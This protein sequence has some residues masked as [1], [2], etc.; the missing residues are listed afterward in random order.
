M[1]YAREIDILRLRTS[2]TLREQHGERVACCVPGASRRWRQVRSQRVTRP[3]AV[4]AAQDDETAAG[5]G[6][7]MVDKWKHDGERTVP[8]EQVGCELRIQRGATCIYDLLRRSP[9]STH[10]VRVP[11]RGGIV[12]RR[13]AVDAVDSGDEQD[14]EGAI[15]RR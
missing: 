3:V 10:K 1:T 12:C 5:S 15:C 9:T 13:R 8:L 11:D 6:G 4:P 14:M 2:H 7:S